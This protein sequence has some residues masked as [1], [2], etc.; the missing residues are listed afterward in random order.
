MTGQFFDE[1]YG[2]ETAEETRALYDKFSGSYDDEVA[3]Q[4]YATPARI[5]TALSAQTRDHTLPVLDFGCGTGLAGLALTEA[6]FQTIDGLDLSRE[7][8][9]GAAAR[10]VYRALAQI[11]PNVDL[12]GTAENYAAV[13]ACGVIG[14]GAAPLTTFDTIFYAMAPGALFAFS[15]NDHTLE[16]PAFEE[17]V[18]LAISDGEARLLSREYGPHLPGLDMGAIVYVIEKA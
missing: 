4:G 10:D 2:V 9:E 1:V 12:R 18:D 15:F 7:M 5:A 17:R 11:D 8:L 14:S 13:V 16:D 3:E 6:G